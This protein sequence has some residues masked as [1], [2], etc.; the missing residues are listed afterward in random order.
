MN[1]EGTLVLPKNMQAL[2]I[3]KQIAGYQII[4]KIADGAHSYIMGLTDGKVL[5]VNYNGFEYKRNLISLP[6][7]IVKSGIVEEH[8]YV[9]EE[10][11]SPL[12]DLSKM[13][14][15]EQKKYVLRQAQAINELHNYGYCHL[16]VMPEHFMQTTDGKIHLID[17]SCADKYSKKKINVKTRKVGYSAPELFD[18][19]VYTA[20]DW[21]SFGISL[22]KQFGGDIYCG[23]SD[24]DI[25]NYTRNTLVPPTKD[26]LPVWVRKLVHKLIS[27]NIN[28][29]YNYWDIVN[30]LNTEEISD[31]TGCR[32]FE[33]PLIIGTQK[34]YSL[35]QLSDF[36]I[37]TPDTD[38]QFFL[39]EDIITKLEA[40]G[41]RY[42]K[43]SST[44]INE[45]LQQISPETNIIIDGVMINDT[46]NILTILEK[47]IPDMSQQ[48]KEYIEKGD[49]K[50]QLIGKRNINHDILIAIEKSTLS[51][52]GT[53]ALYYLLG[54]KKLVVGNDA[55]SIAEIELQLKVD[56]KS[57]CRQFNKSP[58][59][60][61]W[62]EANN[63]DSNALKEE[64]EDEFKALFFLASAGSKEAHKLLAKISYE[65]F[66]YKEF[67]KIPD[68]HFDKMGNSMH[69]GIL[70]SYKNV[71]VLNS[72]CIKLLMMRKAWRE[73]NVAEIKIK[74]ALSGEFIL[75]DFTDPSE[76]KKALKKLNSI[77]D[78]IYKQI[79]Y[80]SN[81]GNGTILKGLIQ[82][83]N[84]NWES[85]AS[86]KA[87]LKMVKDVPCESV[88]INKTNITHENVKK[89]FGRK[90]ITSLPDDIPDKEFDI[91]QI[92]NRI[93]NSNIFY[94][95][96]EQE[97]MEWVEHKKK[98]IELQQQRNAFIV[99]TIMWVVGLAIGIPLFIMVLPYLV[100][101]AITI[102]IVI[103][104]VYVIFSF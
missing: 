8:Q 2:A 35:N 13:I 87:F 16:G 49:F 41:V 57:F 14:K 86:L 78:D 104:I 97:I 79:V 103:A 81:H 100:G 98:E 91:N 10:M 48:L 34:I 26:N 24:A 64:Y 80:V 52:S 67:I 27:P 38:K 94:V 62:I 84:I 99:K 89:I 88:C 77:K 21:Y 9:I 51:K 17:L 85:S 76:H 25:I 82:N 101:I 61:L 40:V 46:G 15:R 31:G 75:S 33:H 11:L 45:I 70:R 60:K 29:R 23:M 58:Y 56:Y 5:R 32:V 6:A 20:S 19:E 37:K 63:I 59:R 65:S 73:A 69:S 4:K 54:G 55:F 43:N 42:K 71:D 3:G 39:N 1:S 44:V 83:T 72:S 7:Y 66:E 18:G 50:N 53:M 92:T 28:K 36:L 102:A 90:F 95:F 96:N 74:K 47:T 22:C 93:S 12:P 68:S 30:Y